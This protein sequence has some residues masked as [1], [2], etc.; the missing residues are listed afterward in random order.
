MRLL[1]SLAGIVALSTGSIAE[2]SHEE[3]LNR[4]IAEQGY[5]ALY[6][7]RMCKTAMGAPW[8]R[9]Q[10]SRLELLLL[11]A[12]WTGPS[13]VTAKW[14]EKIDAAKQ[15]NVPAKFCDELVEDYTRKL[16]ITIDTEEARAAEW[17]RSRG[18]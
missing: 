18:C 2:E 15:A 11:Q 1:I 12:Q 14:E 13:A 4:Q 5:K 7:A 6:A 10:R 3:K 17:C 8:Y 16:Q 9:L